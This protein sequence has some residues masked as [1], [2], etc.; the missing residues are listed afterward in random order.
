MI[1]TITLA[2]DFTDEEFNFIWEQAKPNVQANY[3]FDLLGLTDEE[4][5][6]L[7][8]LEKYREAPL[9]WKATVDGRLVALHAGEKQGNR[10]KWYLAML[11]YDANGERRWTEPG[12]HSGKARD[13]FWESQGV[14]GWIIET[15]KGGSGNI[16]G[17]FRGKSS[18]KRKDLPAPNPRVE[19]IEVT[20]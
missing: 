17:Y 16:N 18:I 4:D 12:P 15:Y 10:I 1:H 6:R 19:F 20:K 3:P 11:G 8:L 2:N 13:A 5:Q 14:S 9:V 7:H